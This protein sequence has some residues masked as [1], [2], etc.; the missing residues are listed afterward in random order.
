MFIDADARSPIALRVANL[1]NQMTHQH[2]DI[3]HK[4]SDNDDEL[5]HILPESSINKCDL[6]SQL[7]FKM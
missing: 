3:E 2:I 4:H 1:I 5:I 7:P 6:E